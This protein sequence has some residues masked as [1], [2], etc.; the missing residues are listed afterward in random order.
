[1]NKL[2]IDKTYALVE[3]ITNKYDDFKM[4]EIL[5]KQK[6]LGKPFKFNV[7]DIHIKNEI[8]YIT[9][10]RPEAMNALNEAVFA[11][12]DARFTEAEKNPAVK[13]I[14]FQGAGKAFVAGA[15]IRY[16]VKNIKENKIPDT[17]E[18]TRKGH[19]LFL[20]IENSEKLTIAILDGLSLGGGSELALACQAIIATPAGSMAFP[21][22]GI[23]IYPGLGGMPRLARH[24]GADLAKYYVFTGRTISAKDSHTL[25]IV[26]ALTGP[27]EIEGAIKGLIVEGKPDK[28]RERETPDKFKP[29]AATCTME[30]VKKLLSGKTPEGV[31]ETLAAKTAKIVGF[32]APLAIK[33]ANEIID[34]GTN[35]TMQEA[36]E[37]E[38][39]RL[40]E[41][42][43]TADAFEGLSTVGRKRPEFKGE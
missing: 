29:L 21:E 38:L 1:M 18:F 31:D 2:G 41:I 9:I 37:I 4:P 10:N 24:V 16:F 28:Y 27:A 19:E 6:D 33:I 11:Q 7:V 3:A 40:E 39:G 43:S 34:A 25:G 32:K 5:K 15:D 36:I 14:A 22:T 17:V 42:F 23:G 26:A 12:L 13:A 8:A 20:R 35:K 30:N